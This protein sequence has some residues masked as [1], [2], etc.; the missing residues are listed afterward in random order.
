M[1]FPIEKIYEE[2]LVTLDRKSQWIFIWLV[3]LF[4]RQAMAL[5]EQHVLLFREIVN[6]EPWLL[7]HGSVERA[8]LTFTG[9]KPTLET[10]EKG[11]KYVK[12]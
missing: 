10:L 8:Q 4:R 12:S 3:F 11:V 7:R 1:H 2:R 6:I 5:P 9:S